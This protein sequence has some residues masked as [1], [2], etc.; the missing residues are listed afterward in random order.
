MTIHEQDLRQTENLFAFEYPTSFRSMINEFE[1]L[2]N[3]RAFK[4]VFP[5]TTLLVRT[6]EIIAECESM[7]AR[8][9]LG[10]LGILL[11][12]EL[13]QSFDASSCELIPFMRSENAKFPDTYAFNRDSS[14]PEYEVVVWSYAD[15][16]VVHKWD[17]FLQF[18]QWCVEFVASHAK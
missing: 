17:G 5:N 2:Y 8:G 10:V 9:N 4:Q 13:T 14:A 15:A 18:H 1:D 6:L 12:I 3:S 16:Q 7:V 11:P